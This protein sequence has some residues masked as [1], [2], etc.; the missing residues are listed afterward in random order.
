MGFI[1]TAISAASAASADIFASISSRSKPENFDSTENYI[2]HLQKEVEL[3]SKEKEKLH[4]NSGKKRA[5]YRSGSTNPSTKEV[6]NTLK[7]DLAGVTSE[8][9]PDLAKLNQMLEPSEFVVYTRH[10]QSAGLSISDF[11]RY[12]H[13]ASQDAG[14]D[15]KVRQALAEAMREMNPNISDADVERKLNKMR[16]K[17]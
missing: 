11:S 7:S 3:T 17:D 5:T 1:N 8:T 6:N 10:L 4:N 13:N 9:L 16:V 12:L 2:A 15:E 14:I